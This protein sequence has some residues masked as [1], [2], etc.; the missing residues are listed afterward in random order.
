MVNTCLK[1]KKNKHYIILSI[2]EISSASATASPSTVSASSTTS[3]KNTAHQDKPSIFSHLMDHL[4]AERKQTLPPAAAD[5][6]SESSTS[7]QSMS[8]TESVVS[9]CLSIAVKQHY[10]LCII[11]YLVFF[12]TKNKTLFL[13]LFTFILQTRT[14]IG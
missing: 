12:R 4:P 13:D 5:K 9:R 3:S 8:K 1:E 7:T 10:V 11:Y 2:S 6:C 14:F